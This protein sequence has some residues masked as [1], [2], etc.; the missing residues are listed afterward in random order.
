MRG[1]VHLYALEGGVG[2]AEATREG[3]ARQTEKQKKKNV[4]RLFDCRPRLSSSR[5][6]LN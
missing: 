1:S 6:T 5:A 2:G 3:L 4:S